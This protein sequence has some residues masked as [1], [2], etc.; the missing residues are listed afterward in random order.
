MNNEDVDSTV[1]GNLEV[2]DA[3]PYKQRVD[4]IEYPGKRAKKK[5]MLRNKYIFGGV[6][7]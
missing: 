6:D 7:F 5:T 3:C 1:D 4:A 2:L